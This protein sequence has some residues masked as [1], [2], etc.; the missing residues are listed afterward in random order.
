MPDGTDIDKIKIRN[1]TKKKK[2]T[3]RKRLNRKMY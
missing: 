3:D 2:R 1:E